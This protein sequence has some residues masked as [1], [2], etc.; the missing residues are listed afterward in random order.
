MIQ[1]RLRTILALTLLA[2][3]FTLAACN[4]LAEFRD[5]TQVVSDEAKARAAQLEL[6]LDAAQAALDDARRLGLEAEARRLAT[7]AG[8]LEVEIATANATAQTADATLAEADRLIAEAE[9]NEGLL[10]KVPLLNL[11]PPP[12]R[13]GAALAVTIGGFFWR[14]Q[15][16]RGAAASLAKSFEAASKSDPAMADAIKRNAETLRSVQTGTAQKIVDQVQ[17][18]R[19][20]LVPI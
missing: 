13:E 16:L 9:M 19:G 7:V 15:K 11:L 20:P 12:Y 17:A 4:P 1:V 5:R 10:E 3:L 18:K 2:A 14:N 6:D 8:L